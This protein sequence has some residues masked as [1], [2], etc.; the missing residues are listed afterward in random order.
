MLKSEAV[1]FHSYP[2]YL[3]KTMNYNFA[4][5]SLLMTGTRAWSP[6]CEKNGQ[7]RL[8]KL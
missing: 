4:G 6:S 5:L 7:G 1:H 3:G 2:V 8:E